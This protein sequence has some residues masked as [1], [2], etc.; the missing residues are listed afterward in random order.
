M[1]SVVTEDSLDFNGAVNV[2]VSEHENQVIEWWDFN[3][4][5]KYEGVRKLFYKYFDGYLFVHD[6]SNSKSLRNLNGWEKE[7]EPWKNDSIGLLSFKGFP[8][9]IAGNK[10]DFSPR[11]S[12]DSPIETVASAA[13]RQIVPEDWN[14]FLG[15]VVERPGK[16]ELVQANQTLENYSHDNEVEE[17][18]VTKF[19]N[20]WRPPDL[21]FFKRAR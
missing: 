17:N 20:W 14:R 16:A 4:S 2:F 8:V 5:D 21:P 1:L 18:W 19:K 9:L 15:Q 13:L 10:A 6:L 11:Y 7:V 3:G 12:T